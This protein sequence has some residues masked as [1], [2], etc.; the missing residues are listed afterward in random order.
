MNTLSAT[1]IGC[2]KSCPMRYYYRYVLGLS[3]V[4][5]T[6]AT[7]MGTN[8]HKIHEIA[9]LTPG[10]VCPDCREI[11]N[12]TCALC[13]GTKTLP[14]N[15]MDAVIRHLNKSYAQMPI[16][17]TVEE[18]ET[19]RITLLYSLIGYQWLYQDPGYVVEKLEQQF[20]IPLT[21]PV[22]GANLRAELIGKIDRTFSAESNRFVHE[23]KSTSKG[24]EPDSTY[25]NHLTLDTQTR[26]YTYAARR[27]G[28]GQVGVLYDV[29]HRP[30]TAP[31]ML[32][33][34]ES[35]EFVKTGMYCDTEFDFTEDD[36]NGDVTSLTINGRVI[37]PEPG[38]KPGT[39][40]IRETPEMYGARLLQDITIRPEY[41]FARKELAHNDDDIAAFEWELFNL[42][43]NMRMMTRN[44]SWTHHEDS[45]EATYK[46]D[47]INFCY[48]HINIVP[49]DVPDG[50]Q[51]R[52]Q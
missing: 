3:P 26:L 20:R 22:T 27:L 14:D 43:T 38:K 25:W 11:G 40:A 48:N 35:A 23:Y 8:Y 51:K 16:S 47:Y 31:K 33:Q 41:Y 32:T 50:F 2:F 45:C 4:S 6:D 28:L 12:E 37:H 17:K 9:D 39:F 49:Q 18:W 1:S 46:C 30:K 19:E 36:R 24:I 7:R 15:I 21:S 42:Y 13:V 44:N 34:G 10:G 52:S 29:W 5:E